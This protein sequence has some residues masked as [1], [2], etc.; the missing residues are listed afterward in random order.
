MK[1]VFSAG[2]VPASSATNK[3]LI[4]ILLASCC[5]ADSIA[6]SDAVCRSIRIVTKELKSE[7]YI[8][9]AENMRK[10]LKTMINKVDNPE[11][12]DKFV[13]GGLKLRLGLLP[14]VVTSIFDKIKAARSKK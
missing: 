14:S 13:E 10:G 7:E 1:S 4:G 5:A 12:L 3:T 11:G 6:I 8:V 2:V 9:K